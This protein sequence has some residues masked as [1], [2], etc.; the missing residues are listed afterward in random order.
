M[1]S[2]QQVDVSSPWIQ[3]KQ[4]L[5]DFHSKTEITTNLICYIKDYNYSR[6]LLVNETI[7]LLNLCLEYFYPDLRKTIL[8]TLQSI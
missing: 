7:I 1:L 6:M 3:H 8:Y 2:V 5:W 4:F